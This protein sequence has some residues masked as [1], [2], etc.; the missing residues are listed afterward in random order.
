[1]ILI[2]KMKSYL[3]PILGAVAGIVD[4]IPMLAQGL[5][6]EADAS[7]FCLWV[8][9]GFFIQRTDLHLPAPLK[10]IAISFLLLTP[11]AILIAAKEPFS[12]IP[13]SIMTLL[14]GAALGYAIK[15][16]TA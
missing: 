9:A 12:L 7:A 16:V 11:A 8:I 1:M 15:K 10:G 5:P 13:I 14:L 6:W 2:E 3:G 4:V